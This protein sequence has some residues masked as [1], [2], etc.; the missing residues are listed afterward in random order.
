M[1]Y[2]AHAY[3]SFQNPLLLT[4]NMIG[5]FVKGSVSNTTYPEEIKEGITLHRKID[6]FT[7]Q[8]PVVARAK[9]LFKKD[10][11][12]YAGPITD[13]LFDHFLAN[14]P[15]YFP[16]EQAL[17]EFTQETYKMLEDCQS[18]FPHVF[19]E[20]FGYMREQNWLLGYRK[21]T[22]VKKSLHGLRRRSQYMPDT[23]R[24]YEIFI[25]YYYQLVQYYYELIEDT[26]RF[27]KV[28]LRHQ[29]P[30]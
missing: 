16:S 23:Q 14:D 10:Y 1:N 20:V 7:D 12:L 15:Q 22:G 9:L 3:L 18:Y 6:S 29:K 19:L 2:L 17:F 8:H 25:G 24:A 26:V 28:E 5:D 27:V 13:S 21:L 11:G 4:G 30:M